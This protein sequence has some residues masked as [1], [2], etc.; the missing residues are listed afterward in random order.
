MY[1]IALSPVEITPTGLVP[2]LPKVG[3]GDAGEPPEVV[4]LLEVV[5]LVGMSEHSSDFG[6]VSTRVEEKRCFYDCNSYT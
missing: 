4:L 3:V 1:I 5:S 6:C 2:G